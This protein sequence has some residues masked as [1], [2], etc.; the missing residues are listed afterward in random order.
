MSK[1]GTP[2]L[3]QVSHLG[4]RDPS[5]WNIIYCPLGRLE[6]SWVRNRAARTVRQRFNQLLYNAHS[7]MCF[8]IWGKKHLALGK[9]YTSVLN[10]NKYLSRFYVY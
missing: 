7:A 8:P 1:S 9:Y 2:N 3:T 4:S 6:G 5:I 10:R